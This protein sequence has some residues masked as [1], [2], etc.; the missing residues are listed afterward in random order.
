M[1]KLDP[2]VL[3]NAREAEHIGVMRAKVELAKALGMS[4]ICEGVAVE[5]DRAV[6]IQAGCD[7]MQGYLLGSPQDLSAI[8]NADMIRNA[9]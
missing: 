4:V 7:M 8:A 9:A 1:L 5:A 3:R 6:A 2:K